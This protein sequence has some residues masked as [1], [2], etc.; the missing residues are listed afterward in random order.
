MGRGSTF[1]AQC[2]SL[3]KGEGEGLE[4][5]LWT[6]RFH[7]FPTGKHSQVSGRLELRE[8]QEAELSLM[9][10]APHLQSLPS[11]LHI[12]VLAYITYITLENVSQ[13]LDLN[14]L[15]CSSKTSNMRNVGWKFPT[16]ASQFE[17]QAQDLGL[18]SKV[19]TDT[20]LT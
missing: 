9:S 4:I 12:A 17:I 16:V 2:Y 20:F 14:S 5:G 1:Q 11:L 13:L 15:S 6:S 19:G 3:R 18:A 8:K 7:K 10:F